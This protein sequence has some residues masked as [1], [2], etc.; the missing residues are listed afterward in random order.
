M[1]KHETVI[2]NAPTA[3]RAGD[4]DGRHNP[5]Q[6]LRD[7]AQFLENDEIATLIQRGLFYARAGVPIHFQGTAGRGK[8][9]I[10]MQIARRLG[11]PVAVMTGHDWLTS[12]DLIGRE[13]GQSTRA[14]VDKYVQ[15]VRRSEA[16]VRHD[17]EHSL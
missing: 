10:A 14:V 13:V 6:C 8:T 16:T 1:S 2:P 5:W 4:G 15:R 9:A 12:H 11:R 7:D 3:L 17:W